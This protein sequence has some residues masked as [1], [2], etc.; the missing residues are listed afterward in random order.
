[1]HEEFDSPQINKTWELTE[2]FKDQKAFPGRWVYEKTYGPING[3]KKYKACWVVKR[4]HQ[5]E[6]IDHNERFASVVKSMIWKFLVALRA[7]FDYKIEQLDI[8]TAFFKSLM[9]KAVYVEQ[10]YG[11]EEP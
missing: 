2:L 1:M 10:T 8:I 3:V 6:S 9:K 7:K 4:F 5:V 11:F